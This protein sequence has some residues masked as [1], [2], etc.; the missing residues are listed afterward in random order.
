MSDLAQV[1]ARYRKIKHRGRFRPENQARG[2][3]TIIARADARA[4]RYIER[5]LAGETL[6]QI[7]DSEG[8]AKSS[9]GD[10]IQH[11]RKRHPDTPIPTG[12][13]KREPDA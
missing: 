12:K 6:K 2:R 11:Y 1:R 7:A 3:D 5:W 4:R 13:A 8:L 9:V 10:C